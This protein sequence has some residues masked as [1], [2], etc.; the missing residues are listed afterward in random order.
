[1]SVYVYMCA[2]TSVLKTHLLSDAFLHCPKTRVYLVIKPASSP[3]DAVYR[4]EPYK[5]QIQLEESREWL[6][7]DRERNGR[8]LVY[9]GDLE[10]PFIFKVSVA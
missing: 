5:A 3:K 7:K 6:G 8:W 1:M 4:G 2:Q 9:H 10:D